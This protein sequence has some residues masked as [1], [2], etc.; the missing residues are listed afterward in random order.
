MSEQG[1]G[2]KAQISFYITYEIQIFLTYG[3]FSLQ[4]AK[5][6]PLFSLQLGV[7]CRSG[8]GLHHRVVPTGNLLTA[9]SL[10][11]RLTRSFPFFL[12]NARTNWEEDKG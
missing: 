7:V 5:K 3:D 12:K 11:P 1:L 10:M 6:Q 9:A 4:L 2:F 8:P